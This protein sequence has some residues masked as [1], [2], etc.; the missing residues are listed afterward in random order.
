MTLSAV[1][2]VAFSAAIPLWLVA[3]HGVRPDAAVIGWSL[4]MFAGSA[5]AGALFA[6][7][8]AGRVSPRVLVS[9]SLL[10]AV[11]P[12]I[13]VLHLEP[14]MPLYFVAVGA[15]G[16]LLNA[17]LPVVIVTAQD[18]APRSAAATA[19]MLMGLAHGVAGLL[20]VGVGALQE[21]VG[22][23][24][25]LTATSLLLPIAAFIAWSV[26]RGVAQRHDAGTSACPCPV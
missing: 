1:P 4:S 17:S 9:M 22:I 21:R 14:G 19:G 26:L 25:A 7:A 3:Q 5:A 13:A 12:V 6:G 2:F 11:V 16:A 23:A 10:A 24:T 20:Y 15:S 8:Y 18:L